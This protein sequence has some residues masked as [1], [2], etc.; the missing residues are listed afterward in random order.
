[1]PPL[2]FVAVA[3]T[4]GLVIAHHWLD[5]A[6]VEPMALALLLPLPLG[7]IVLWRRD[8]AVLLGSVCSLALILGATRFLLAA[9]AFEDATFVGHYNDTG[10]IT[11]EGVVQDYP[12]MRSTWTDLEV[13]AEWIET[14]SGR[15]AVEGTILVQTS[16]FPG[17]HYGDRLRLTGMLRTPPEVEGSAYR[18]NLASRNIHSVLGRASAERMGQG[19][20]N[21]LRGVIYTVKERASDTIARL[22][23]DPEAALLQ[24]MLLGIE[25][26]IPREVYA[27]F[28]ATGT[29]H[30]IVIS[31]ANI[32]VVAAFFSRAGKRLVGKRRSYWPTLIGIGLYVLLVGGDPVVFRAGVMGALYVTAR[33]IGRAPTAYVSLL[34]SVL[35]LTAIEPAS[36][37][38]VGFQLSFASTLGLVFLTPPIAQGA[39][40]GL[41]RLT[42][43]QAAQQA[44]RYGID[45][46]AVTLAAQI[47]TL[48][49]V[50]HWFGRLSLV[51]PLTNLLILP[52]QTPIMAAGALAA[53]VGQIPWLEPLAQAIAWIPWLCLAYT[54][55]VVQWMANWPFAAIHAGQASGGLLVGYY[56][57]IGILVWPSRQVRHE[58]SRLAG[59]LAK[60]LPSRMGLGL[61]LSACILAWLA[62]AQLPD[63]KL[64]VAFL[65]VGQGDA[66]LITSPQG[67]QILVDG[68]PSP[69]ALTTALGKEMPFWD[70]SIDVVILSHPDADHLT[71]LTEVLKRY[72]VG[73]W[74]DNGLPR[75]EANYLYCQQ[76]LQQKGVA[77]AVARAGQRLELGRGVIL[78]VLH[79]GTKPISGTRSDSNNNSIVLRLV[80][81]QA[82]FL[83]TGDAQAE[84]ERML[85]KSG[86]VLSAGILKVGH[87]GSGES[88]TFEFLEAVGPQ[89]A[90]ISVG[91]SNRSGLPAAEALERLAQSG[92]VTILRTDEHGRVEFTT[93]GWTL[94]VRTER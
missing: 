28:N 43:S 1:M 49:L 55:A 63:G 90:V 18:A 3:W 58:L 75:E 38:N 46:L 45:L 47:M 31:G 50:V 86:Q 67:Q 6:G 34:A 21:P 81:E 32:M 7:A 77:Q 60:Q 76:L 85:L 16:Q 19:A 56:L 70:R 36:L 57:L 23:R 91:A 72:R 88:S 35:L 4:A 9:P 14:G 82:S 89:Y 71:G 15:F 41:Q 27:D 87:H 48:P 74:L 22:I 8:R 84:A 73:A 10:R 93:D 2:V 5:P 59:G 61:I 80:W 53:M 24:G 40:R 68:G 42:S 29:S 11:L 33:H 52:A 78:D 12:D 62:C 83:L 30:I 69:S 39:E 37:W 65:D 25:G 13:R 66:I 92:D 79:P 44:L 64:H 54:T 26:G 20:G 94:Q 17:Y 51:A